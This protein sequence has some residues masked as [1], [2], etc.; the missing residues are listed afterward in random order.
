MHFPS[1]QAL[2]HELSLNTGSNRNISVPT[3]ILSLD[4]AFTK[5]QKKP[6]WKSLLW[7]KGMCSDTALSGVCTLHFFIAA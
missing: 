3:V 5:W 1:E 4:D 2:R 7:V 6:G